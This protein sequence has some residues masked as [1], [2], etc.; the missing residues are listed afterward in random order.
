MCLRAGRRHGCHTPLRP[1]PPTTAAPARTRG[2]EP[3]PA[4]PGAPQGREELAADLG[5]ADGAEEEE[6][7]DGEGEVDGERHPER[8][9]VGGHGGLA[10]ALPGR[11]SPHPAA[12]RGRGRGGAAG[13]GNGGVEPGPGPRHPPR[14]LGADPHALLKYRSSTSTAVHLAGFG[15]A[16]GAPPTH[17]ECTAYSM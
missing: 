7:Q 4:R 13:G 8:V 1:R 10:P 2:P 6:G 5:A 15:P 11:P 16:A 14:P 9:A 17:A 3:A 12:A